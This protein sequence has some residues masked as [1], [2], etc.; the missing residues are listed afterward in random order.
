[1][2]SSPAT[3]S[4]C[5]VTVMYRDMDMGFWVEKAEAELRRQ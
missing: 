2:L 1:V 4:I 3:A 5:V